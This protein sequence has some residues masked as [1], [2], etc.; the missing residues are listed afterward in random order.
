MAPTPTS[1]TGREVQLVRY[2]DGPVSSV[3]FRV[4]DVEVPEPRP[5]EVLVRNTW[6]SIDPGL[7]LRLR[8]KSPEGYFAALPL[9]AR[10]RA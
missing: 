5:G 2:P 1:V 9:E 4:V 10:S 6:M 8:A 7:R 3:D